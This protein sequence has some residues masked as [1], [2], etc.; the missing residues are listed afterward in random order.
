MSARWDH[1]VFN[2]LARHW[3]LARPWILQ[4]ESVLYELIND[5]F[6]TTVAGAQKFTGAH[7][8]KQVLG[9]VEWW[10]EHVLRGLL[11]I[12]VMCCILFSSNIVSFY[13]KKIIFREVPFSLL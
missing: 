13:S 4:M 6:A 7:I 1:N 2:Q 3:I 9:N 8:G 10:L 12:V 11:K 5:N